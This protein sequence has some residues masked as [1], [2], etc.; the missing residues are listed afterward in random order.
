[1]PRDH[2]RIKR[3]LAIRALE[4][5]TL[6]AQWAEAEGLA[7]RGEELASSAG[8]DTL[9]ARRSLSQ[10]SQVGRRDP[11]QALREY[12]GLDRLAGWAQHLAA[13]A[14][15][16]RRVA[17]ERRQPWT[18]KRQAKE[19]LQ[20]LVDASL[21][22][23]RATAAQQEQALLDE[24]AAGRFVAGADTPHHRSA[25][26]STPMCP[27]GQPGNRLQERPSYPGRPLPPE[28]RGSPSVD[29]HD[30]STQN[31]TYPPFAT[32]PSDGKA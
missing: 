18:A 27:T 8:E 14:D 22:A 32:P 5:R 25:A 23:L 3:V 20:R 17:D 30:L 4:E 10:A 9:R 15:Q 13:H 24:T 2:K 7:S 16:L 1:M 21:D 29:G 31:R 28:T 11:R 19:G 12:S 6:R 26:T